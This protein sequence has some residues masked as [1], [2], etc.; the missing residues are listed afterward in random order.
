M[1]SAAG[2]WCNH[3][4][5][6][7]KSMKMVTKN[8]NVHLDSNLSL[9][10]E[11]LL[12]D[13]GSSTEIPKQENNVKARSEKKEKYFPEPV[14]D[15]RTVSLFP[16]PEDI[17]SEQPFLYPNVIKGPYGSVEHYLDTHFKLLRED[18]MSPIRQAIRDYKKQQNSKEKFKR[19]ENVRIYRKVKFLHSKTIND[20]VGYE[21][22]FDVDK[23]INRVNW[24]FSNRFMYGSLLLFTNDHFDTFFLAT[25][26][27]RSVKELENKR[28]V[29]ELQG[30]TQN[31]KSILGKEFVMAESEAYFEPYFHVLKALQTFSETNFPLS[32]YIVDMDTETEPPKYLALPD[33]YN[34]KMA[35]NHFAFRVLSDL[36]WPTHEDLGLDPSQYKAYKSALTNDLVVIQGPPGTG[37]TFLGLQIAKS[38]LQNV[39]IWNR[40]N[41]PILVVC[42][43]NHALD[44]FL[45][46]LLPVTSK[47]VRIGGKSKGNELDKFNIRERRKEYSYYKKN[48][49]REIRDLYLKMNTVF[50]EIKTHQTNIQLLDD[51]EGV[52]SV[53]TLNLVMADNQRGYFRDDDHFMDWLLAGVGSANKTKEVKI[54]ITA[55]RGVVQEVPRVDPLI[56]EA[57][58]QRVKQVFFDTINLDSAIPPPENTVRVQFACNLISVESKIEEILKDLN[59]KGNQRRDRMMHLKFMSDNLI[60]ILRH[61]RNEFLH[62]KLPRSEAEKEALLSAQFLDGIQPDNRWK[63]YHTWVDNLRSGLIVELATKEALF[64]EYAF[65]YE[66]LRQNDDLQILK[67]SHVVGTTTTIAAK[68]QPMFTALA[69]K[70][71]IVEEAA[72][73]LEAH[74]IASLTQSCEHLIM[75]GDHKQLRP[76]V[77]ELRLARQYQLDVSLFERMVSNGMACHTLTLQHRMRPEISK[78]LVPTI[79][80]ELLDHESVK[81]RDR[82]K[83]MDKN[84]FFMTH[85]HFED[86]VTEITSKRN[87]F[88]AELMLRLAKY[89]VQQGYKPDEITI[90]V[91]YKGQMYHMKNEIK[92]LNDFPKGIQITVVDNFQ[93]EQN[94]IILLSLV[95]SNKMKKI[96]FLET[97]NRVCVALSRA[98]DGL[99]IVGNM[100]NLTASSDIWPQIKNSLVQQQAFGPGFDLR[101][102]VHRDQVTRVTCAQDFSKVAEGGCS[103]ICGQQLSC[104]HLC[105]S[106]CHVAQDYHNRY[107]CKAPCPKI[108]CQDGHQCP[109]KCHQDCGD[110]VVPMRRVLI[111]NHFANVPCYMDIRNFKCEELVTVMV[112][113]CGHQV[114]VPCYTSENPTCNKACDIRLECGH[115]CDRTCHVDD[116]PD[117]LD[118]PCIKPCARLNKDCSADHKCK[119]ACMEE[120]LPCPVKTEKQLPCGHPAKVLCSTDVLTVQCKRKCERTLTCGHQC[121]DKKCWQPCQPCMTLVEKR[122][123][124]CGHTVKVACSQQPTR[125]LCDGACNV[126]L[127]CGHKCAKRCKDICTAEDCEHPKKFKITTLLCGHT[128]ASIPCNKAIRVHAM[129]EEELMQFCVEP[130]GKILTC[131]HP[132]SGSCSECMQ[133]RIHKVCDQPCGNVLICGHSC[134]VP[135]RE[136]CPPCDQP[137]KHRCKHSKC[138]RKCGQVCVPCKE[139][140]DYKCSH[141]KCNK[142]CGEPCDREPCYEACP[143]VLA[144]THPC[145]GFCGEPCPPCRQCE[146]EHF[147]EFFFTGEETEDDAKWVFLQDCKHTLETTGLEYWLNMDQEGSEIVAKTCPRCKTSI[148][149]TQR[150]MNLI[151]KTYSDVQKVK[152]KCLG[153]LDEIQKERIKC[154]RRLQEITFVKMAFPVNEPDNLEVLLANLNSELPEVKMKKR[155]V[156]SSQKS[157]LLCFFTEFFILLYKRKEEI[158]GKLNN[159][160]QTTLTKK[161]NFLTN[162]LMKRNQ[163]INEQEM[164]SFEL[165]VRRILRLCDLMIYTSSIE[166]HM[167][168]SYSGATETRRMAESIIH[169]VVI[170]NDELDNKMKELL[171]SLKKQIKSST[172]ISNEEREMINKAMKSSFNSSQKTG[173]WFKCKNGHIYC[174]TEC[175]GAMQEAICPERGCGAAIGGQNHTL[176]QDQVL[177]NEM[178]GARYAAWSDQNNM[179]NFGFGF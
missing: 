29:I 131:K 179:A 140:C 47:L 136:V 91:T 99:Y 74:I 137:C 115:S 55:D 116:D 88:E 94:R 61:L 52:L 122:V 87:D 1:P 58:D 120:C 145:V 167:A 173:H 165:E 162:L 97:E 65:K 135:C 56:A 175:G 76:N 45:A 16:R 92:K 20:K 127:N 80:P 98:R 33:V 112:A 104:G 149:T 44:Q 81:N 103:R 28:V 148:V 10:V 84:M 151:K 35:N 85:N 66:L 174:I 118:Y 147:E 31:A 49:T 93:G 37:K 22:C 26:A 14:G 150:F 124:S 59:S 32:K 43:T 153:K 110:C 8:R 53:K 160:A 119:M 154:I 107:K 2:V 3:L 51:T 163:K 6:V 121:L 25:V 90:L 67:A 23:K 177:A 42:F 5:E 144:C 40:T 83:G 132:C 75:I 169:S 166:Y 21:I 139:P 72:E 170:Y 78:Q 4:H 133:G 89:L 113:L 63:L 129:S 156:L 117:H 176:R 164:K 123:P 172:E 69:P 13:L 155:N 60:L 73:V 77:A 12:L 19:I 108:L 17:Y 171:A 138:V 7:Q 152:L 57:E 126:I 9:V 38:L 71:V 86:E 100:E 125:Q 41:C 142:L 68:L 50:A 106:M 168:S 157:Q 30:A 79:Y 141:L 82:I 54:T 128:T 62:R 114:T 130:C 36:E 143:I 178:D 109:K 101:C 18:F 111:C 64:K 134:P 95:R 158:W 11:S 159:E 46:G 27:F 39:S 161:I 102:E 34:I 24:E 15:F 96:G 146:P 48:Q 105:K 70:I